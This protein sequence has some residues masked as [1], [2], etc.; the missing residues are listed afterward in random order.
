MKKV[1][2]LILILFLLVSCKQEKSVDNKNERPNIIVIMADDMGYSDI[3]CY[4][5][6]IKTPNLDKLA[7][8]GLRYKQF[9]N[10]SRC[11]PTRAS[12][13]TGLYAHQTGLGWMT[14][15]DMK[16]PGYRGE[17]S[18]NTVTLAEVLKP[19]G[20]STYMVGKWH[21][22]K[23]DECEQD[24]PKH[25]WP[26]HRGFDKFYGILKGASDYFNPDNLYDGDKHI[27]PDED[28]YFTDAISDK[29][30]EYIDEH[31]KS[32]NNP[33]FLYVA[34]IAPHWPIQAKDADIEKYEGKYLNGWENTRAKRYEQMKAL[35]IIDENVK[36]SEKKKSIKDWK[37]LTANEKKEQDRRMAVYA[38]Q[39]DNLDQNVGKIIKTLKKDGLLENTVEF[40]FSDNGGCN[41]PVSRGE[42]KKTEDI[43]TPKSF[44]S[45][46]EPWANVSNTPF[47]M[48]KKW[49]HEGG[50]SSPLIV[51]WPKGIKAEGELRNQVAH[52]ID[53]MP[54]LLEL[55]GAKYPSE[56]K[57]NKI[58]PYE[59]ESLVSTFDNTDTKPRTLYW[60]HIANRGMREG[61]W[62]I[63][64]LATPKPPYISD[65]ELYDLSEDRSETNNL[66]YKYPEKVKE[67]SDK[68]YAWA[69]RCNVL[70]I[71]GMNWFERIDKYSGENDE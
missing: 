10:T 13:L 26:L 1:L 48:F 31:S 55:S 37:T 38:A 17:I 67:M 14:R 32:K 8:N 27:Q 58:I 52:V 6:E 24:S 33:F 59:G 61:N 68:W 60:E 36:L 46:G 5:S 70:P 35:G 7:E 56:Y 50:I 23:D 63:V 65:W 2:P 40:F 25:N 47:R 3:G 15:V 43:G 20:Y 16:E 57:D 28:F 11:C 54:T 53:L 62:K 12:L 30:C 22:N 39:V 41:L 64:S 4:G 49:E 45:Y 51:H 66:A 9:Y 71:N 44:E 69:K 42:S 21:V 29:A 19:A 18:N 34:H